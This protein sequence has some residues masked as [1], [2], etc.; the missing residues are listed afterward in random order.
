MA[1]PHS[2]TLTF[3][4]HRL[5]HFMFSSYIVYLGLCICLFVVVRMNA[6]HS[7]I[8]S[9]AFECSDPLS[10]CVLFVCLLLVT[11]IRPSSIIDHSFCSYLAT[12]SLAHSLALSLHAT[13]NQSISRVRKMSRVVLAVVVMAVCVSAYTEIKFT[14]KKEA[15]KAKYLS[16]A[17]LKAVSD[18]Y[19]DQNDEDRFW[20]AN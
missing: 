12:C 2:A 9:D 8:M 3:S 16:A 7:Q 5:C 18:L 19:G 4:F 11:I 1:H 10:R 17:R 20:M 6:F 14:D 13:I 15:V